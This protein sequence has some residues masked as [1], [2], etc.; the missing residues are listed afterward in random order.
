[1]QTLEY[2]VQEIKDIIVEAKTAAN[3]E[4]KDYFEKVLKGE[5]NYPCG[6]AWVEIFGIKGNTKL[7]K[8]MKAAGLEKDYRGSYNIWNPSQVNF[9]NMDCKEAGAQA[10]VKLLEKYG[11]KAYAGSRMD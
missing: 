6:F 7:G 11:F 9:Q 10:A 8:K 4:A 5:D 3:Y 1:M 2:T